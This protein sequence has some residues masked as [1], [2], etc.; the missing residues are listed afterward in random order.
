MDSMYRTVF[1]PPNAPPEAAEE[2]RKA[3]LELKNDPEFI[4]AYELSV[5]TKPDMIVGAQG[6]LILNDLDQINPKLL[7]FIKDYIDP[8]I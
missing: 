8:K 4:A 2:M 3:F 5:K 6:E 7:E 1:M